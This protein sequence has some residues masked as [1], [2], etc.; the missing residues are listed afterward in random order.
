M[1]RQSA[2][3]ACR[4]QHR[5]VAGNAVQHR[6]RGRSYLAALEAA[7]DSED[8]LAEEGHAADDARADHDPHS[9]SGR[10]E[11]SRSGAS[12]LAV[13]FLEAGSAFLSANKCKCASL[14]QVPSWYLVCI[15]MSIACYAVSLHHFTFE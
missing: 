4:R 7:M 13:Q 2:L 14:P 11:A 9:G 10:Q 5:V 6:R 12:R 3:D 8:D 15:Y 1:E